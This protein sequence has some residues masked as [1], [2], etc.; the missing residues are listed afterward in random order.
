MNK[1]YKKGLWWWWQKKVKDTE[2]RPRRRLFAQKDILFYLF[3]SNHVDLLLQVY[4]LLTNIQS[5]FHFLISFHFISNF[6][7][8]LMSDCFLWHPSM[9]ALS[10]QLFCRW[11]PVHTN[12]QCVNQN[13][14]SEATIQ[15]NSINWHPNAAWS[16]QY[17]ICHSWHFNWKSQH[18][19]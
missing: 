16:Y 4:L 17:N 7:L 8:S 19:R 3:R 13:Q 10:Q 12:C 9:V 6:L 2:E 14:N 11:Y 5:I 18:Y 15:T 1:E